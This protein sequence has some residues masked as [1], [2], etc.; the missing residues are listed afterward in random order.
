MKYSILHRYIEEIDSDELYLWDEFFTEEETDEEYPTNILVNFPK[1]GGGDGSPIRINEVIRILSKLKEKGATHV[2][3]TWHCD[4][5]E[6]EFHGMEIR[7]ATDE[8]MA[9]EQKRLDEKSE[10]AKAERIKKLQEE[11]EALKK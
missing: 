6:Y 3:I 7:K 11:I 9:E 5:L 1:F 4:H 8:E 2:E 10:A